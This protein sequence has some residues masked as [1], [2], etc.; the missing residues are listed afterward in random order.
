MLSVLDP[1]STYETAEAEEDLQVRTSGRYGG[2]GLT[3]GK[4]GQED[5]LVLGALEGFAF[6][7]GV[8]PGDRLL[9]VDGTDV[10]TLSVDEVKTNLRGEPGTEVQVTV[11][12]DG[13]P[14]PTLDITLSRKLV[15]LPDATARPRRR[16]TSPSVGS[17]C[18][19]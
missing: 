3:I 8:R 14:T 12:R 17:W 18:A 13:S 15:R 11:Q 10:K 9:Q 1:Y 19:C 4:D 5:V 6:D 7:A 2:V 16:S